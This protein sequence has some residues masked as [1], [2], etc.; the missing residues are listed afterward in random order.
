[1]GGRVRVCKFT[2]VR[3]FSLHFILPFVILFLVLLRII[4][5][6]EE[7]SSNPLGLNLK[8]KI[9]FFEIQGLVDVTG[10]IRA[11]F[12]LSFIL[13]FNKD[14]FGDDENFVASNLVET[15]VHIQPE[16]YFL[17]AH[18]IL[19]SIPN[20]LGGVIALVASVAIYYRM[21]FINSSMSKSKLFLPLNKSLF[22]FLV[23]VIVLLTWIGARPVE[24]PYII[25]GQ[26]LT[27]LYFRWFML[28]SRA[29]RC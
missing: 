4:F 22:W 27:V 9:I 8:K 19:R 14:M 29:L 18:A 23:A 12:F 11:F 20:K 3:F 6:H 21:P 2:L 15:P 1:M 17:F 16:W 26:L 13:F 24:N 10:L 28:N 5:L 25:T 7:G